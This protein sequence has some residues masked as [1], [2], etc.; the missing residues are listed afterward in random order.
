MAAKKK[1]CDGE[2]LR[3]FK[4]NPTTTGIARKMQVQK[5]SS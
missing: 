2:K 5:D 1:V 3:Q 4:F